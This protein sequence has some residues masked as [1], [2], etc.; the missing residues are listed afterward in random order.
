MILVDGRTVNGDILSDQP[1][2]RPSNPK[3]YALHKFGKSYIT[4]V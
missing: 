3:I 4:C 2:R 1:L